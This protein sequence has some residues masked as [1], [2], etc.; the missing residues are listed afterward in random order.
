[1][2]HW[3]L[4]RCG[5]EALLRRPGGLNANRDLMLLGKLASGLRSPH[6]KNETLSSN[7]GQK[8]AG[9]SN[10]NAESRGGRGQRESKPRGISYTLRVW[11]EGVKLWRLSR[12]GVAGGHPAAMSA[13]MTAPRMVVR[14]A[15]A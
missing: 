5:D 6:Y 13:V 2:E 4:Q 7:K 3:G 10:D 8:R 9:Y 12:G 1:M 14:M 11:A 15:G